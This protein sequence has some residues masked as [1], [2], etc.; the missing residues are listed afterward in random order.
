MI[1]VKNVK[2][3]RETSETLWFNS[4]T[5][6]RTKPFLKHEAHTYL[7]KQLWHNAHFDQ[8]QGFKGNILCLRCCEAQDLESPPL[9]AIRSDL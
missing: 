5:A 2:A 1:S 9:L 7:E 6:L 8:S 4:T 3:A